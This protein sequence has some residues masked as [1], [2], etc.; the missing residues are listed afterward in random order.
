MAKKVNVM[1][2]LE[3]NNASLLN[4]T[5]QS[6]AIQT[7][8]IYWLPREKVHPHP[9]EENIYDTSEFCIPNETSAD[10]SMGSDVDDGEHKDRYAEL[11]AL[12]E[13]IARRGIQTQLKVYSRD[14]F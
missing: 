3:V 9:A 11:R 7:D 5:S 13:D 12:A 6:L 8:Q 2:A 1:A 14:D 10:D 4:K